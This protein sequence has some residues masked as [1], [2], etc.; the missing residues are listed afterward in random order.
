MLTEVLDFAASSGEIVIQPNTTRY[1]LEVT[2]IND[3]IREDAEEFEVGISTSG[4]GSAVTVI[5][6]GIRTARVAI[7]DD[8]SEC[9]V[10]HFDLELNSRVSIA[11]YHPVRVS[12]IS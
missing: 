3:A 6:M 8:D 11:E 4:T 12:S 5:T 2:I 1:D 9:M 7:I 10:P